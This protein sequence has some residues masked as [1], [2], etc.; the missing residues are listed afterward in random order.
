MAGRANELL[1][2]PQS[3]QQK[4]RKTFRVTSRNL[5][6]D[7]KLREE[8]GSDQGRQLDAIY[9]RIYRERERCAVV[10]HH[11]SSP[12]P[13]FFEGCKTTAGQS[14]KVGK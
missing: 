3:R 9:I 2:R 8:K 14:K 10:G 6:G 11:Q 13:P 1:K 7:V 5:A 4:K 12:S